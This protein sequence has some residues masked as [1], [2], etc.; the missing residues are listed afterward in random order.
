MDYYRAAH[1]V[2]WFTN[3]GPLSLRLE[4]ALART[5]GV[6]GEVCVAAA[7]ATA[8]LSAALLALGRKGT[9]LVPA[10]TFPASVGAV[11]ASGNEP[12]II[13]IQEENWA[14]DA[15]ELDRILDVWPVASVMLV[16]PFGLPVD[17]SEHVSVCRRHG[18]GV[19]I[20]NAAGLGAARP[21][22]K[23]EENVFEVFS[24]HATKPFGIGEGGAI[25]GHPSRSNALRSALNFSL[26]A[27]ARP[28]LP[29]WGFNGK[30]S[31]FHAAIGLAQIERFPNRV[32][33][34][35]AFALAYFESLSDVPGIVLPKER[36]HA[37]W[38]IFPVL[39]PSA[40][41][42]EHAI[43]VAAA[44]G[45][46]VRRYYNP[47]LSRWPN[48]RTAGHC[49]IAENLANRMCALPVRSDANDTEEIVRIASN[50]IR[51]G[52][53]ADKVF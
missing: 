16:A 35:Q 37:V 30:M 38:Q 4:S 3:F 19:V 8:G 48:L 25:F 50:S 45:L 33:S 15:A 22:R 21:A 27:P 24:L 32:C 49:H 10:F 2:N 1:E 26:D 44:E 9:V 20:D 31:E 46:E 17:F 11:Y 51:S 41:A 47:S 39:M 13:D 52:V 14:V 7:N 28:D 34:R 12:L 40:A 43:S 5:F 53:R 36:S 18:V 42:R 29:P 23:T 6:P